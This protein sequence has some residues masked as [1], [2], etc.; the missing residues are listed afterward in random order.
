MCLHSASLSTALTQIKILMYAPAFN[1]VK[2]CA[3]LDLSIIERACSVM[4]SAMASGAMC[5]GSNPA[6]RIKKGNK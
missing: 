2:D 5:A 4:D 1:F 3:N 6:R